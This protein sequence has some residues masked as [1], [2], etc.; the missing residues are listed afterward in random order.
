MSTETTVEDLQRGLTED[1]E[2]W[3]AGIDRFRMI[4]GIPVYPSEVPDGEAVIDQKTGRVTFLNGASPNRRPLKNWSEVRRW[5]VEALTFAL[6]R[7]QSNQPAVRA[8]VTDWATAVLT[9]LPLW[10]SYFGVVVDLPSE[11]D[12]VRLAGLIERL[13]RP[14]DAPERDESSG[15]EDASPVPPELEK[16]KP[17]IRKAY[18]QW[19]A[20]KEVLEQS[21][22]RSPTDRET[23]DEADRVAAGCIPAFESW[24]RYVRK[25]RQTTGEGKNSARSGRSGRSVVDAADL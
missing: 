4:N 25:A 24:S 22:A 3:S 15:T 8:V 14:S 20:A 18:I 11:V 7:L 21:Q 16:L 1:R 5:A 9:D 17:Y 10:A 12:P 23:W 2:R 19:V 13:S 6:L